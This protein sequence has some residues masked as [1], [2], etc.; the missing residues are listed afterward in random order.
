MRPGA[1]NEIAAEQI[2]EVA[3]DHLV[4]FG[5]GRVIDTAKAIAAVTGA[6][7]AAIPTT[8]SGAEMTGSTS[9]PTVTS[10]E[11]ASTAPF[12]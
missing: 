8:L 10:R 7:V 3:S 2:S 12:S 1:V 6:R 4:A 9:C 5:G 11:T